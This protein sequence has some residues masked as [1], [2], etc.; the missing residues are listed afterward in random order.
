MQLHLLGEYTQHRL[1]FV[2]DI[3]KHIYS[4]MLDFF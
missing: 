4:K 2:D 3:W 1:S